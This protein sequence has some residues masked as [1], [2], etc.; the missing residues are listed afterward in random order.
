MP[1]TSEPTGAPSPFDRHTE[2][3]S[4]HAP[5]DANGTPVATWA[6]QSRA[7]SRWTPMPTEVA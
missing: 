3:T 1:T 7:P 6:F 5:Y 2:I 4:A